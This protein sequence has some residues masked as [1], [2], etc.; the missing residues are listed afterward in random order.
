[1]LLLKI[2]SI[3]C[4]VKDI[5]DISSNGIYLTKVAVPLSVACT[6]LM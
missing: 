6:P 2:W 5:C 4:V 3:P 1:M